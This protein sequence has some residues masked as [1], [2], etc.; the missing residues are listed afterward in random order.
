[1][2][3]KLQR[4]GIKMRN[5]L[6]SSTDF[7]LFDSDLTPQDYEFFQK[8]KGAFKSFLEDQVMIKLSKLIVTLSVCL[9]WLMLCSI[10]LRTEVSY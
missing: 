1:M 9:C 10:D 7:E 2:K 6:F 3:R 8:H 4:S 5:V